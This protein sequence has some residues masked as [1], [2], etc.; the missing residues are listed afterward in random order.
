M[1][2]TEYFKREGPLEFLYVYFVDQQSADRTFFFGKG[3]CIF[4]LDPVSNESEETLRHMT[5][6][7]P[8]AHWQRAS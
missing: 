4:G 1:I 5:R 8:M 3:R 7:W 2:S 6:S